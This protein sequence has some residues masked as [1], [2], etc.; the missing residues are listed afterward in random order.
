[1]KWANRGGIFSKNFKKLEPEIL[2]ATKLSFHP[3][4]YRKGV[5]NMPKPREYYKH[6]PFLTNI[7]EDGLI[8]PKGHNFT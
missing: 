5:L 2:Q 8:Q 1:M 6:V 3:H 4:G 7:L